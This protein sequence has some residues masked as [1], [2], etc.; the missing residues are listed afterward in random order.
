MKKKYKKKNKPCNQLCN[1]SVEH[2]CWD[3]CSEDTQPTAED[4]VHLISLVGTAAG[5][6]ADSHLLETHAP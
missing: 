2:K 4:E 1:L 6:T 5:E 3:C